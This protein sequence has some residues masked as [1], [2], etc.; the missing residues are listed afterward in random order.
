MER[1]ETI[2]GILQEAIDA[3]T[4]AMKTPTTTEL[5][6]V[7]EKAVDTM[8]QEIHKKH[9][10]DIPVSSDEDEEREWYEGEDPEDP[11]GENKPWWVPKA[12]RENNF[13]TFISLTNP[14]S[15]LIANLNSVAASHDGC[16]A[17]VEVAGEADY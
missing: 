16:R 2:R 13:C 1:V 17:Q 12:I 10:D 4:A 5:P 15:A 9:D 7:L 8:I 11:F 6:E 14:S 3:A